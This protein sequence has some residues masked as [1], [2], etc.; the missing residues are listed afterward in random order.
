ML[1]LLA[2]GIDAV[3]PLLYGTLAALTAGIGAEA[4]I[5]SL[6]TF[7]GGGP[8]ML[9]GWFAYMGALAIVACVKL[10]SRAFSETGIGA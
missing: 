6:A 7:S 10:G 8:T 4:G 5:H 1:E 3:V 2:E 9:A